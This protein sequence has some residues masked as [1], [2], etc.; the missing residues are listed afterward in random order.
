[1]LGAIRLAGDRLVAAEVEGLLA[2]VADRPRAARAGPVDD[3]APPRRRLQRRGARV[4]R[5]PMRLADDGILGETQPAADLGRG[6][7]LSP[8]LTKLFNTFLRP[9]RFHRSTA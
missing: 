5:Q 9:H 4:E 2:G 1:M 8:E 6:Q 7:P 3:D